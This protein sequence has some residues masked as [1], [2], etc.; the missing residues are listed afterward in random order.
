MVAM[1]KAKPH[2]LQIIND[3]RKAQKVTQEQI[4]DRIGKE[5]SVVSKM[6]SGSVG[7]GTDELIKIA[8]ML[9]LDTAK[10]IAVMRHESQAQIDEYNEIDWQSLSDDSITEIADEIDDYEVD[11]N[12][13]LVWRQRPSDDA[14]VSSEGI[15]TK[16]PGAIAEVDVTAGA[17]E[18]TFGDSISI[19][20]GTG[21]YVG[22]P[23][24]AEWVIPQGFATHILG[25]T[26]GRTLIM[27]VVGDSMTPT[28]LPGDRVIVDLRQNV[29]TVDGVYIIS[30][31]ESPPQIKRL[32]RVLFTSPAEVDIVSDNPSHITQRVELERLHILG[33]VAGKVTAA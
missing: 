28:Y 16:T 2:H 27:K 22:H 26:A 12:G 11:E 8:I 21:S 29:L 25:I 9:K 23:V 19:P 24:V 6:L 20:I 10:L 7:M 18:G 4:A 1:T 32:Q 33:R 14:H 13:N 30:D 15:K 17:G 3:A 5:R 31:G